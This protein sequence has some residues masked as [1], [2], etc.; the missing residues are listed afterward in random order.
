VR[1]TRTSKPAHA[2]VAPGRPARPWAVR[3]ACRTP[4]SRRLVPGQTERAVAGRHRRCSEP[5]SRTAPRAAKSLSMSTPLLPL[6]P[7]RRG[8]WCCR[9]CSG[10]V[11]HHLGQSD[12][13]DLPRAGLTPA[14]EPPVGRIPLAVFLRHVP[15]GSAAAQSPEGAVENRPILD[16]TAS[17]TTHRRFNRQQVSQYRPLRLTQ[18]TPA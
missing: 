12:R 14:P 2:S 18:I 4:C 8:W 1:P 17:A 13:H 6:P 5:Y 16:R 9:C 15:P 7:R 10:G 3:S 11:R